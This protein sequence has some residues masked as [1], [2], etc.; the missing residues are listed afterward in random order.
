MTNAG[1][2]GVISAGANAAVARSKELGA[3]LAG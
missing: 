1:L 2:Q 3:Q